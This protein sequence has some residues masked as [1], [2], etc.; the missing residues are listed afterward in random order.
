MKKYEGALLCLHTVSLLVSR[1]E[2]QSFISHP[3]IPRLA[4]SRRRSRGRRLETLLGFVPKRRMREPHAKPH[5]KTSPPV[6][7]IPSYCACGS[8]QTTLVPLSDSALSL[9]GGMSIMD[10]APSLY[11]VNSSPFTLIWARDRTYT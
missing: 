8:V 7:F 4:S 6:P 2:T 5:S 11:P 9:Y 10:F 1:W 3:L